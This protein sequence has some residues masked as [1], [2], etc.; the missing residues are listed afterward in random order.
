MSGADLK[1]KHGVLAT[2]ANRIRQQNFEEKTIE[3][4]EQDQHTVGWYTTRIGYKSCLSHDGTFVWISA[5]LLFMAGRP[6]QASPDLMI[7]YQQ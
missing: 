4:N 6:E 2:P 5:R 1:Y 3:R 7:Y